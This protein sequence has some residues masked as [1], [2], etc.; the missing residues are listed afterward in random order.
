MAADIVIFDYNKIQ[1]NATFESPSTAWAGME[2][3]VVNGVVVF[4]EG[5]YT[6]AKRGRVLRGP[7]YKQ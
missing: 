2:W 6:G 1:D 5:R 7:G 3:V 4:T